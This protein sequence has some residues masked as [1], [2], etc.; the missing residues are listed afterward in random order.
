MWAEGLERVVCG[1][2]DVTTCRDVI[3]ALARALGRTGRYWLV[4]TYHGHQRRL[5]ASEHLRA[6][7]VT[8]SFHHHQFI[9]IITIRLCFNIRQ[10][11][12]LCDRLP[13]PLILNRARIYYLRA[14]KKITKKRCRVSSQSKKHMNYLNSCDDN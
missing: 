9:T 11:R 2:T 14:G 12:Q 8:S 4:E 5:S 3:I 6:R 13:C 10:R 1:V 7:S